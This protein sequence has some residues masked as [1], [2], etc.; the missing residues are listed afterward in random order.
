MQKK[1]IDKLGYILIKDRKTLATKSKGKNVWFT[2]GGKREEGE[3]DEQALVREVEEELSVNLLKGTIKPYEV[4][5]AQAHGK[6][7]GTF[8]KITCYTA[9][10]TGKLKA[11]SEIKE[12]GWISSKDM[13]NTTLTGKLILEDLKNKNLI[14]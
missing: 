12:I 3:T 10:Y 7:E 11:N 5:E 9:D 4:F 13:E 14:D 1:Y 8:V 2:P 6:P